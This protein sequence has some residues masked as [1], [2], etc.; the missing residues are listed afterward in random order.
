MNTDFSDDLEHLSPAGQAY[1]KAAKAIHATTMADVSDNPAQVVAVLE[2]IFDM[3]GQIA[4][5][6]E[7]MNDS[8][9]R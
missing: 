5:Q 6:L 3:L 7:E 8:M 9:K 4:F 2:G 1:A